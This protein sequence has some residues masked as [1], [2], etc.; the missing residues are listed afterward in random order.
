MEIRAPY[1]LFLGDA[2]DSLAA[3]VAIGI[4]HWRPAKAVGQ[5]RLPGCRADTGLPDMTVPLA[6]AAGA[7]TLVVGVANRGGFISEQW[8]DVLAEALEAGMDLAAGLHNRLA[9]IPRL[10]EIADRTGRAMHDVRHPNRAFPVGDGSPRSGKRLLTVGT[11]CSV[12]KMYASLAL[13]DE[14]RRRGLSVDFRATGQTGI[15]IAGSGVAVDA[16]VADFISGATEFLSP[17]SDAA[18]WDVIEGQG[19]LCH[20]SFAGVT[21]GLVHGAQP[22]VLVLCHEPA[23]T[24]MRGLPHFPIPDIEECMAAHLQAARLTNP[25]SRFVGVAVNTAELDDA[26]ARVVLDEIEARLGLPAVDPVRHGVG[27]V[28]DAIL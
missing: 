24:H 19:S 28:I 17:A 16:V 25:A 1:V 27:R 9:D 2:E 4:R 3:K 12:G 15:L 10:V 6:R 5:I 21:M 22:D 23:R 18:H 14:M 26:A 7:E 20:P 11:D 8:I 13:E